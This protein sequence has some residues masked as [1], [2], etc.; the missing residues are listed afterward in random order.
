MCGCVVD[1]RRRF[2]DYVGKA[3]AGP[4]RAATLAWIRQAGAAEPP[5][6]LALR[7]LCLRLS[8]SGLKRSRLGEWR[9]KGRLRFD[10]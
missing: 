2:W 3:P 8:P 5:L 6:S 4:Q 10:V 1:A 7:Q 9:R